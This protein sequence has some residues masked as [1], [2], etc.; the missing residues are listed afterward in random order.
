MATKRM[1]ANRALRYRGKV[2]TAGDEFDASRQDARAL[3]A[4]G[5]AAYAPE[6]TERQAAAPASTMAPK[7]APEPA[8]PQPEPSEPEPVEPVNGDEPQEAETMPSAPAARTRAPTKAQLAAE[9]KTITGGA[10]DG[11]WSKD[12]LEQELNSVRGKYRRR[13]MRAE[14]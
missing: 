1:I 6:V 7:P 5:R 11:R 13:D 4:L 14:D 12:R 8:T 3:G 10:P 2:L 9:Y